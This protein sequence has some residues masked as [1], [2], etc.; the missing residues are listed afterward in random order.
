MSRHKSGNRR[1]GPKHFPWGRYWKV[2]FVYFV[3]FVM[4]TSMIDYY[5][6]MAFNFLWILLADAVAALLV[7][8]IHVRKGKKDH[9]DEVADE[10]L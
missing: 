7:G 10:L 1:G 9:V 6:M 5:A 4:I 2:S 8:W 3:V